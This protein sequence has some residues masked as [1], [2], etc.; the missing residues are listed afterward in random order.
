[1]QRLVMHPDHES[2]FRALG[3]SSCSQISAHFAPLIAA[4]PKRP[5]RGQASVVATTLAD[6]PVYYKQYDFRPA[7]WRYFIR[8]SKARI[9]FR[10]NIAFEQM[11]IPSPSPMAYAE[12][13]NPIGC[14]RRAFIITRSIPDAVPL[15]E[16]IKNFAPS[17]TTAEHRRRRNAIIAQLA[18]ALRTAHGHNFYHNDLHWR[19]ILITHAED[20]P[21]DAPKVWWIDCP[22][23]RH[24]RSLF[25][26][27]HRMVKDLATLDRTASARC[28]RTERLR[29]LL[30]YLG[31]RPRSA[32]ERNAL[33][34]L[35]RRIVR[36]RH[37]RWRKARWVN[38]RG[39]DYPN[40][41]T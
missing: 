25:L 30:I 14:L 36:Y 29:F 5:P 22:R 34:T 9:E 33:R 38:A 37:R 7:S 31:T 16:Y 1:M 17:P 6:T 27:T 8:G 32:A 39:V 18:R 26:R 35:A 12:I 21:E 41:N 19:N 23:G 2:L 20:A 10:N 40:L 3:L 24:D 13:R 4:A 11:E 15:P 28:T